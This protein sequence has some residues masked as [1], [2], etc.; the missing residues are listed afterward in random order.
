MSLVRND[1]RRVERLEAPR[2]A[3]QQQHKASPVHSGLH[4]WL[5]TGPAPLTALGVYELLLL[6]CRP[7]PHLPAS[8]GRYLLRY[9]MPR[10]R[11]RRWLLGRARPSSPH[12]R[13]ILV[14]GGQVFRCMKFP[15]L[16]DS[17]PC[18][19]MIPS[20]RGGGLWESRACLK[21]VHSRRGGS[22]IPSEQG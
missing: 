20:R 7:P 15:L 9:P 11:A 12:W 3:L 22:P 8:T 1:R 2:Q 4:L 5:A 18:S 10:G 19:K 16:R 14:Y 6:P 17:E 21:M 13:R